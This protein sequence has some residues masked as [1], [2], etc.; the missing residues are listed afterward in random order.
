MWCNGQS[1]TSRGPLKGM[2][3]GGGVDLFSHLQTHRKGEKLWCSYDL[4]IPKESFAVG[5]P[6]TTYPY[7]S[8]ESSRVP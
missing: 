1:E 3:L 7:L 5:L 8:Q 2:L 6:D 4:L